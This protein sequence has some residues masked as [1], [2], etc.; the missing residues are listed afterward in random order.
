MKKS[1]LKSKI[2][3]LIQDKEDLQQQL[4][5]NRKELMEYRLDVLR[6][7]GFT[8]SE[9]SWE[10]DTVEYFGGIIPGKSTTT[11]VLKI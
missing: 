5:E 1:E 8:I 7:L 10:N 4:I 9:I 6:A 11:I 3:K 2:Q